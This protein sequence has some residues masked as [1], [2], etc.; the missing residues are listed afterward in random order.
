MSVLLKSLDTML[1]CAACGNALYAPVTLSCGNTVCQKCV[2]PMSPQPDVRPRSTFLC[3]VSR[4]NSRSHLFGPDQTTFIDSSVQELCQL[5][6]DINARSRKKARNS[7]DGRSISPP[8]KLSS[9]DHILECSRCDQIMV[10]PMTMHC[11]HAYCRVCVLKTKIEYEGC[12]KCQGPLPR[13]NYLQDQ[14]A[15]NRLL[16]RAI[17]L[18]QQDRRSQDINSS[19]TISM[20]SSSSSSSSSLLSSSAFT[21][22]QRFFSKPIFVTGVVILPHQH[23]RL[24]VVTLNHLRMLKNATYA[25]HRCHGLCIAAVHRGRPN[26]SQYG[27]IIEIVSVEQYS[28]SS[29]IIDVVGRER[30]KVQGEYGDTVDPE[31]A[32]R[33]SQQQQMRQA[34]ARDIAMLYAD[35][36]IVPEYPILPQTATGSSAFA[37]TSAPRETPT[38]PGSSSN[39]SVFSMS[40]KVHAYIMQLAR[41]PPLRSSTS[42]ASATLSLSTS[43][44]GLMGPLWFQTMQGIHGHLPPASQPGGVCWWAAVVLPV[45][46]AE[47]YA[48]LRTLHLSDRLSLVWSWIKQLDAQWKR[49]RQTA[50]NSV[51]KVFQQQGH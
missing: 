16:E 34:G 41:T 33:R 11:G 22:P 38:T 6:H 43:T 29:L 40:E 37:S 13:Y 47:R 32:R 19:A 4:C 50:I 48:L 1:A 8:P 25:D 26:L 21:G 28:N 45:S 30:F 20:S 9:D 51:D 10:K 35:I 24:P 39:S 42:G 2:P 18:Y 15:I 12:V 3:P 17:A 7:M 46:G 14:A 27:T 31:E 36:E 23:V 5:S 49:C 44:E